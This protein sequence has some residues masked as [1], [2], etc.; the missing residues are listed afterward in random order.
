MSRKKYDS[1]VELLQELFNHL[2]ELR[3]NL[4]I[5]LAGIE[6]SRLEEKDYTDMVELPFNELLISVET[7]LTN[8][9]NGIYDEELEKEFDDTEE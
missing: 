4:D 9:D 5:D 3:T 6:F 1:K 7:F 2:E 8:V